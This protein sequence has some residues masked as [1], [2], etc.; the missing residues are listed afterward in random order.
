MDRLLRNLIYAGY[1]DYPKW[2]VPLTKAHLPAAISF[3][4]H[5]KIIAKLDGGRGDVRA[6]YSEEFP[7]RGFLLCADCGRPMTACYS[8]GKFR[9]Y[10]YYLC[11]TKGCHSYGK[12]IGMQVIHDGIY[13]LLHQ[14]A[15]TEEALAV[16]DAFIAAIQQRA[17][18]VL[19]AELDEVQA[20]RRTMVTERERIAGRLASESDDDVYEQLKRRFKELGKNIQLID[21]RMAQLR[22]RTT[23]SDGLFEHARRFLKEPHKV[24]QSNDIE[25]RR[26][27]LRACFDKPLEYSRT[28]GFRTPKITIVFR[29][30]RSSS[31]GEF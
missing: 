19:D 2:D 24:W 21:S 17:M 12:S 22:K 25:A 4:M 8:K 31:E 11:H 15:P 26:I 16:F 5:Q 13:D 1:F 14:L 9:L 3:D 20:Q 7:A 27:I 30:L 18:Q 23:Q 29:A 6:N 10:P 28:R